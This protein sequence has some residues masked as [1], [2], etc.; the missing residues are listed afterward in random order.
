MDTSKVVLVVDDDALVLESIDIHLSA[1]GGFRTILALGSASANA[2][3]DQSRIDVIIADVILT[4]S[5]TG[6]DLC[7]KA[8][9]QYPG[10]AVVVI[11]ADTEVQCAEIP[12]RGVFLRKPF[13]GEQLVEAIEAALRTVEKYAT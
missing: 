4:G 2:T 6:L 11:T 9:T 7:H 10:V 8:I 1:V 13:G 12:E 5:I 3:L